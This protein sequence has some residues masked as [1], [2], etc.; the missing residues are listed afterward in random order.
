MRCYRWNAKPNPVAK[1]RRFMRN[2]TV[3][4]SGASEKDPIRT[5]ISLF[6]VERFSEAAL[7]VYFASPH[8]EESLQRAGNRDCI[9]PQP[10]IYLLDCV[11]FPATYPENALRCSNTPEMTPPQ[12]FCELPPRC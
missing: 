10:S 2:G 3:R 9:L 4:R 5:S 12:Q 8:Q 7:S 6:H 1:R 11:H